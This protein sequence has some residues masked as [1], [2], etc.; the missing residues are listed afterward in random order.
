MCDVCVDDWGEVDEFDN[1]IDSLV[2]C[3]FCNVAVH[4]SCYGRELITKFPEG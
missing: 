3:D 4:Q 1:D 2:L